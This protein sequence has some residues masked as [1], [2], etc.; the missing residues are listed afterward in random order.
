MHYYLKKEMNKLIIKLITGFVFTSLFFSCGDRGSTGNIYQSAY[1]DFSKPSIF[2]EGIISTGDYDTHPAFSPSG[3]TLYFIKCTYDLGMSTIC[4]SYRKDGKWTKPEVAAFSGRYLDVDPFVTKDGNTIYFSSNRPLNEGDSIK[5]DWDIWKVERIN[6]AW[7]KP[8]HLDTPV[9]SKEDEYYPTLSD[10][11]TLFFGSARQGGKGGSDIYFSKQ[12]DGKY[13]NVEN[14]GDS[15][16]TSNNEYEP[17]IARDESYLIFMATNPNGL[18][19]ADL[20]FSHN[21]NGTWT[22][23]VKLPAAIN[24]DATEWSPKVTRDDKYF[25]FGSTR[26]TNVGQAPKTETITDLEKRLN[27]A[28]NGLSDIYKVEF[29]ALG[30]KKE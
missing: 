1:T 11:G 13:S 24:S 6:N 22:K 20:Y 16:N 14:V 9:N 25:F 12:I 29:S 18:V 7:G 26:N 10:S 17:F 28:G 2:E 4:V 3:D 23:P 30:I 15:I 8:I 5:P 27:S 19:H 21:N